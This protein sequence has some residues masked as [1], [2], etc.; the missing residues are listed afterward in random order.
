MQRCELPH[1][2]HHRQ[3]LSSPDSP[4]PFPVFP[5]PFPSGSVP[6]F[7]VPRTISVYYP[8]YGQFGVFVIDSWAS[9]C[10]FFPHSI[11]TTLHRPCRPF[12]IVS[13]FLQSSNI[14]K[15]KKKKGHRFKSLTKTFKGKKCLNKQNGGATCKLSRHAYTALKVPS[16]S[17]LLLLFLRAS[18]G[19]TA[20]SFIPIEKEK[21]THTHTKTNDSPNRIKKSGERFEEKETTS[22]LRDKRSQTPSGLS[23]NL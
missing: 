19:N 21:A 22:S 1:L 2:S 10:P 17:F 6:R 14:L 9:L 11:P 23:T 15:E 13:R 3:P 4:S 18:Q 20:G 7:F 16:C 12:P 5:F 8:S